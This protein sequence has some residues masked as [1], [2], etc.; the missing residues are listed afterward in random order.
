M[1]L[2]ILKKPQNFPEWLDAAT[3]NLVPSAQVRVRPEI[4]A[5]YAEAVKFHLAKG[6]SESVA[7]TVAL[8]DLGD[9]Y[10]AARRFNEAYLS[11][12]DASRAVVFAFYQC[13]FG[14]F[15][16]IYSI[17]NFFLPPHSDFLPRLL[18]S[19]IFF[20]GY[21]AFC[22]LAWQKTTQ[23]TLRLI[24]MLASLTC[25]NVGV[26]ALGHYI[27]MPSAYGQ[28]D[29]L[30]FYFFSVYTV[31]YCFGLRKKLAAASK[32]DRSPPDP[33]TA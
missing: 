10:A 6:S 17:I 29:P 1:I 20:L 14:S 11:S 4:A 19:F 30:V 21:V 18:W 7:Q 24:I 32:D 9:A 15:G 8:A 12:T 26:L 5:H 22:V 16:L 13:F 27:G 28:S 23:V 33:S 2:G 25:L 3:R 31:I